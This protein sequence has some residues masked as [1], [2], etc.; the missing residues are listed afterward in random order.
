MRQMSV[1][2]AKKNLSYRRVGGILYAADPSG[3][4]LHEFNETGAVIWEMSARGRPRA[5]IIDELTRRFDVARLVAERDVD[6]FLRI[7]KT[8]NLL[9]TL[10]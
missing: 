6:E 2:R 8:K 10:G 9:E 4:S 1:T 5:D 3:P 7:L